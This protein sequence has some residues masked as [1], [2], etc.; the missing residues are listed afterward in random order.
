MNLSKAYFGLALCHFY[1]RDTS[2]STKYLKKVMEVDPQKEISSMFYPATFVQL[3][4]QARQ[5]AGGAKPGAEV[6]AAPQP[7]P[8]KAEPEKKAEGEAT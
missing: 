2:A 5:E 1:L 7:I 4:N 3:F 6:V 8:S